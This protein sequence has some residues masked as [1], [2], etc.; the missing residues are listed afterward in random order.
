MD[1]IIN[2]DFGCETWAKNQ[3]TVILKIKYYMKNNH[4]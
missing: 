1:I 3:H 2:M 4:F